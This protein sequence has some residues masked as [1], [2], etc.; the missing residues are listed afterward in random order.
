MV[1]GISLSIRSQCP[2]IS[3]HSI[4]LKFECDGAVIGV[5][6]VA[7]NGYCIEWLQSYL[8]HFYKTSTT[9]TVLA[10]KHIFSRYL[11]YI[12]SLNK[13][14]YF[15]TLPVRTNQNSNPQ[16]SFLFLSPLQN[17][18]LFFT[19]ST[20]S[21]VNPFPRFVINWVMIPI[22]KFPRIPVYTKFPY[23]GDRFDN[24]INTP[25]SVI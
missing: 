20:T 3:G 4:T 8:Q 24:R 17:F 25:V 19:C 16:P 18:F 1:A 22:P 14:E 23:K 15:V 7:A 2:T 6:G 9:V 13:L 5:V 12:F 21:S 10:D 11:C